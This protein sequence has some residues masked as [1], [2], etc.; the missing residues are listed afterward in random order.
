MKILNE[1]QEDLLRSERSFLND[2]RVKLS[3]FNASKSDLDNLGKAI[4]QLDDLFLLVI[5]GEFNSGKTAVINAL[6]GDRFLKEGITPTT[7]Q[8][9]ILRYREG[10]GSQAGFREPGIDFIAD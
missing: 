2:L 6:L 9:N 8:I 1:T 7:S 5:V 10:R 4:S 3:D